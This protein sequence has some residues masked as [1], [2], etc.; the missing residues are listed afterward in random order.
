MGT[1]DSQYL[2]GRQQRWPHHLALT[3][4]SYDITKQFHNLPKHRHQL[5]TRCSNTQAGGDSSQQFLGINKQEEFVLFLLWGP[6]NPVS[7]IYAF[8]KQ[9]CYLLFCTLLL[10]RLCIQNVAGGTMRSD[11]FTG[12][13]L[14]CH[15]PSHT[16]RRQLTG[17]HL[18]CSG[19]CARQKGGLESFI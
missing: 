12:H 5:G 2:L 6:A 14:E 19:N 10:R 18:V 16:H 9:T 8:I 1:R 3:H 4:K 17:E 7:L 13:C 11:T 15:H